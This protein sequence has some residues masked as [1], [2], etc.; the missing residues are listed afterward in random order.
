MSLATYIQGSRIDSYEYSAQYQH[1][2]RGPIIR[3][4]QTHFRSLNI[5]GIK[6]KSCTNILLEFAFLFLLIKLILQILD[7]Q[8]HCYATLLMKLPLP[9]RTCFTHFLLF[10]QETCHPHVINSFIKYEDLVFNFYYQLDNHFIWAYTSFSL[11]T[12][13]M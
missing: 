11:G 12:L 8:L 13:C 9:S 2:H 10:A 7:H 6:V 4:S 3:T 1:G 5:C